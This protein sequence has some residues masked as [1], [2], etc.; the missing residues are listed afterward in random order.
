MPSAATSRF[1]NFNPIPFRSSRETRYLTGFPRLLGS[2]NPC[3]RCRSHG[4]F[5]LF[6]LQS[7]HLN[8][9]YY[10]KIA[11]TAAPPR[12]TPRFCS[13][14]RASYSSGPGTCPDGRV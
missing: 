5:P 7:S 10:P 12:L 2:T 1:R 13:D 9:C 3:A 11:P 6:G 8:I 14:R 4:T